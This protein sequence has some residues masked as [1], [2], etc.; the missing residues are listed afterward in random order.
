M[1]GITTDEASIFAPL[2]KRKWLILAVAI[3]VAAGTYEYYKRARPLYSA[4]TEL[5]L[6]GTS[7]QQSGGQA[8]T[9]LSSRAVA[10]QVGLINSP[11]IGEIVRR[12][13][14]AE[15]DLV[16]ARGKAKAAE[17][18]SASDF[19]TIT[20]QGHSPRVAERLANTYA[21]A[22]I[23][24]ERVGYLRNV[25]AQ[26]INDRQQ[27]L[28]LELPAPGAKGKAA[29]GSSAST[30]Q[31]ANLADKISQLE[32]SLSTFAGVQ[33]VSPAKAA[34]VPISPSPKRNAIFGFVLGLL[35]ASVAAYALSR[36]DRRLRTLNEIE[37]VFQTEILVAL[38][39]VKS[40]SVRPDG[41]RAPAKLLVEPLRRLGTTLHLGHVIDGDRRSG[42]RVIL[43]LST[44]AGDGKSTL[45]ANLARVQ[46]DG[47]Q[48]VAVVEADF[49]RPVQA[50]LLDA[51]AARG[52]ADVLGGSATVQAAMQ[53]VAIAPPA[54]A[55]A[56]QP[57][58]AAA[59]VSTVVEPQSA[60]SLSVLVSG[61]EVANP[62]ALLAGDEM[63][64]LLRTLAD[65]FDYVLIDA[66][67]P[68]EVSDVMPLLPIVDGIVIVAR[69]GHTRR[70]SA[71]RLAQLLGRTASAPVLGAVA[72]CVPRK[73]IERYGFAWAPTPSR[74]QRKL[75]RT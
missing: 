70:V 38:P 28:R 4:S 58:V 54:S 62:P 32:S 65:E 49:R 52:L 53:T 19:I 11:I 12:R 8:K 56:E 3:L 69:V 61:G 48:R 35:L 72:N 25:K 66:P 20:T 40:P 31:I 47:G 34:P 73:D 27:L 50:R 43:F 46:S 71:Q 68:L 30:L 63:R 33:Q 17:S 18:K 26:I 7:E 15:H 60:G 10:N 6:G 36:M 21:Q 14:R 75:D 39:K 57:E 67:P 51:T 23:S 13:L 37:Q 41:R 2:W 29:K 45:I 22:Y 59:G 5:Y 16:A 55:R 9:G 64:E 24:R 42:P 1:N 74:A 44:D